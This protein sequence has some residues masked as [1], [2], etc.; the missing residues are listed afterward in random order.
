MSAL[1]LIIKTQL[2]GQVDEF[3]GEYIETRFL[4]KMPLAPMES[5][6]VRRTGEVIDIPLHRKSVLYGYLRSW[7][8]FAAILFGMISVS[9]LVGG[10]KPNWILG[11]LTLPLGV[12]SGVLW[13]FAVFKWGQVSEDEL[14]RRLIFHSTLR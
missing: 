3:E 14:K 7:L 10:Y 9:A 11:L 8:A 13:Y 2:A 4:G 1:H 5:Y 6:F 12:G